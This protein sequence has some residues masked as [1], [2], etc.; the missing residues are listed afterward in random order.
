MKECGF[1]S[2]LESDAM[3]MTRPS[4]FTLR[5]SASARRALGPLCA[6]GVLFA[7]GA[8]RAE[9]PP[10]RIIEVTSPEFRA[11]P[12]AIPSARAPGAA[13]TAGTAI[14]E[15]L[16]W[17]LSVSILFKVLDP[18]SFLADPAKEGMTAATIR[19]E[20]W[21]NVGAEGLVKVG[22]TGE[23]TVQA[24]FRFFDVTSGRQ[25]LERSYSGAA[26]DAKKMAHAFADDLIAYLTGT[27]G[28]YQTKIA[29]VRKTRSGREVWVM[30]MDGS[31]ASPVT[32]NGSI[33]LLPAWFPDGQSLLFTSIQNHNPSMFQVPVTGGRPQILSNRPGLNMGGAVSPDG[34]KVALTLTKDGNSEIYV[35]NADGSEL[36]R[37]TDEWA[38]DSSPSWSPD[39]RRIAF[40]SSRHGDPQIFVMNA[41]GS[42]VRRITEQGNYNQTPDWSPRGDLIVFTARDER[43]VFDIFTVEPDTKTIRRLTQ[44]QGNNEEPTFS[45]DG[46]HVVF[47]S[48]REGTS[49]VW[50]MG[51]DGSKQQRIT[52]S[53]GW[54]TPAWSPYIQTQSRAPE[55]P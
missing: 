9:D 8:A 11:F 3:T 43:N 12:I 39:G 34:R 27:P 49:Q 10:R 41:D 36:T 55:A 1:G 19:F 29:A 22:V 17:D 24:T 21:L 44:D 6:L 18:K 53:G 40:V 50:I 51:V 28:I 4:S 31:E 48:T 30:N 26:T 16:Q 20:D 2:V 46:N 15:Q 45:P 42:N 25:L 37:L 52:E 13:V 38:I 23:E 54:L 33:N 7:A 32:S 47:T 35:M 5:S 14:T